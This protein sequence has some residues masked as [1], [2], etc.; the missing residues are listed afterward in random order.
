MQEP[1]FQ[2]CGI[3]GFYLP[4]ELPLK[5]FREVMRHSGRIPLQGFNLT[6][7]YKEKVLRYLAGISEE[8]SRIGA[9]NTVYR[10]GS[11]WHG[12]NTDVNG[13]L[14]SL[15]EEGR[16]SF[17]GGRALVFGAGGAARAVVYGLA[18]KGVKEIVIANRHPQRAKKLAR[19][20]QA[21]F[22]QVSMRA[23]DTNPA[24]LKESLETADLV[25]N[26]TSLG[27]KPEDPSPLPPAL[28]PS[29]RGQGKKLFMDLI[30]RPAK[31]RFLAE[32]GRRKHAVLNGAGMLV[33]Q[34]AE[35]F[36]L[37]TGKKAPGSL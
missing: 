20:F 12:A 7:P 27:L 13:F 33:Y 25:V 8:A 11:G 2:S 35:A 22:P 29:G 34:G 23:V 14:R 3:Q 31:T 5:D 21:F 9:V 26:A 16:Y 10:K 17:Q 30:Y 32:A 19:E 18:K 28:I 36:E 24:S 1:A 6:V 37:W 15:A 4:F